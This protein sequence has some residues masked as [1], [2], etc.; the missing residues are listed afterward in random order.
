MPNKIILAVVVPVLFICAGVAGYYAPDWMK[1][2][3]AA[4]DREKAI[5]GGLAKPVAARTVRFK[6][7]S[8]A[9]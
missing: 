7:K 2:R 1:Q 4:A 3:E 5:F 8:P 9:G 6:P